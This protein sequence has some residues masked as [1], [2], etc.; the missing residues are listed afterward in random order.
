M[1]RFMSIVLPA[2][3]GAGLVWFLLPTLGQPQSAPSVPPAVAEL[4]QDDAAEP[5]ASSGVEPGE[6][7][8][9]D[10][11]MNKAQIQ[12]AAQ[13]LFGQELQIIDPDHDFSIEEYEGQ[14][15]EFL[16]QALAE[17]MVLVNREMRDEYVASVAGLVENAERFPTP[18]QLMSC[19]ALL[20]FAT[21]ES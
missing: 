15:V 11:L 6:P 4:P 1:L 18:R 3:L 10:C 21:G 8:C 5:T 17:C 12:Q 16:N 13:D 19:A 9:Q 20:R 14:S 2:V 7:L